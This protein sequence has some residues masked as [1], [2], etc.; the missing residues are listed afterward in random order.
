VL[1][2]HLLS[3]IHL[4]IV[5]TSSPAQQQADM[6]ESLDVPTSPFQSVLNTPTATERSNLRM[7]SEITQLQNTVAV[8]SLSMQQMQRTIELQNQKLQSRKHP[9]RRERA[10][11]KARSASPAGTSQASLSGSSL[12]AD[13]E[14]VDVTQ[15]QQEG[16]EAKLREEAEERA[17]ELRRL[18]DERRAIQEAENVAQEQ[19]RRE[20]EAAKKET[21]RLEEE[22]R[23][24]AE[25]QRRQEIEAKIRAEEEAAKEVQ[26]RA[27]ELQRQEAEAQRQAE[28]RDAAMEAVR[29]AEEQQRQ[30]N[31]ARR[32]AEE[33]QRQ[34]N[35]ARRRAEEQQRQEDE[36]RRRAEEQRRQQQLD[37][38]SESNRIQSGETLQNYARR[39][40]NFGDIHVDPTH[41]LVFRSTNTPDVCGQAW[42]GA[43]TYQSRAGHVHDTRAPP[44]QPCFNCGGMHWRKDCPNRR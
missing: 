4:I 23:R 42:I 37:S 10:A 41:G 35:E 16:E 8:L 30:E 22:K 29:R 11:A 26:R 33:R 39:N 36:A 5:M 6:T 21:E 38:L 31:E 1:C 3:T 34:E 27:D 25:E 13:G 24:L 7:Q 32:R 9:G 40:E 12:P 20:D 2:R 44:P 18:A 14:H 15:K 28:Q 17:E 19:R 43:N